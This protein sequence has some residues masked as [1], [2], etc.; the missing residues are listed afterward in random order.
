MWHWV[1]YTAGWWLGLL[2]LY[3]LL[4]GSVDSHELIAGV[5]LTGVAALS[6]TAMRRAGQLHFQ[7]HGR[8]LSHFRRLP[9]QVLADCALVGGVLIRVLCKRAQVEGAFRSIPFDPGGEDAESAARRA[10]VVAGA[11]LA[12]NTYVVAVDAERRHLLLH[13]LVPS[14]QPPGAGNREWPL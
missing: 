1:R 10:L 4:A 7:P 11:C 5:V 9:G 2:P 3:L 6:L 8:W 14:P 13:Q 12:P